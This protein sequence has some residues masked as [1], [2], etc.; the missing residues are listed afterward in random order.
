[1][2]K[3]HNSQD[4]RAKISYK[5]SV[6][7]SIVIGFNLIF[8]LIFIHEFQETKMLAISIILNCFSLFLINS[9]SICQY[10]NYVNKKVFCSKVF[11]INIFNL[12]M[13]VS[14]VLWGFSTIFLICATIDEFTYWGIFDLI[15]PK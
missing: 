6:V 2:D 3:T 5:Q 14:V 8:G 9:Y 12:L 13:F 11:G 1:M 10:V 7:Y 15:F 4:V